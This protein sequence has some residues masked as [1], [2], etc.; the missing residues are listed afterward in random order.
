M[1]ALWTIHSITR[2][3]VVL[4]AIVLTIRLILGLVKH[5]PY[6]K[7]AN[8]LTGAFGGLMDL[9]MLLGLLFFVLDGLGQTGF[10]AYRWE[11]AI[12][13]LLAV[14]AAHLPSMW[15]K[16]DDFLRTRNTLIAVTASLLLIIIGV[17]S[18]GWGRWLHVHGLF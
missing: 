2:W 18:L 13:M 4:V 9:Q 1:S 17:G 15:K 3:L 16:K 11:H 10:P 7:T 14:I 5:Q 6:D 12:T 8:A